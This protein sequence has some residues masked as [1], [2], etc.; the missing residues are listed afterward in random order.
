[1]PKPLLTWNGRHPRDARGHIYVCATSRAEAARYICAWLGY[2]VPNLQHETANYWMPGWGTS[3]AS[4]TPE[5]GIWYAEERS[6]T[7]ERVYSPAI[8]VTP[9]AG[10]KP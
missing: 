7:P 4:V 8:G 9:T 1:M 3:M 6:S 5:P 2:K 10:P